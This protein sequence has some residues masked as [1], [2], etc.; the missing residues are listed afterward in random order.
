MVSRDYTK[1]LGLKSHTKK[2]PM[3]IA[4]AILAAFFAVV[5]Y[6]VSQANAHR[7]TRS[8]HAETPAAQKTPAD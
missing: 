2:V 5:W 3:P 1:E 8:H 6:G 7:P 4:L